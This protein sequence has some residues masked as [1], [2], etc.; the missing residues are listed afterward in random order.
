[1]TVATI[2]AGSRLLGF[3][4]QHQKRFDQSVG[5]LLILLAVGVVLRVP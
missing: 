3:L 4:H 2:L 5:V 1:V